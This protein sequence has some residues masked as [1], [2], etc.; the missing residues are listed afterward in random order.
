MKRMLLTLLAVVLVLGLFAVA[1]FTGYRLGFAQGIQQT[2]A[3]SNGNPP[4]VRPFDNTGPRG[5]HN[6]GF[7]REIPR[8]F[9]MHGFPLMGFFSPFM[10]LGRL[11]FWVLLIGLIYWLFTRSGWRLTRQTVETTPARTETVTETRL[12]PPQDE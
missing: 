7:G 11:L 4:Q 5:M 12:E 9:G 3:N 6:F 1:G 8:G 10:L 2:V